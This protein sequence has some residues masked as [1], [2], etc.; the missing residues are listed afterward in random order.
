[1]D[2]EIIS[3]ESRT[4]F[5]R[6][7][8]FTEAKQ[9]VLKVPVKRDWHAQKRVLLLRVRQKQQS[10]NEKIQLT[11]L[12][13]KVLVFAVKLAAKEDFEGLHDE[14]RSYLAES[15]IPQNYFS[16]ARMASRDPR[17]TRGFT[18]TFF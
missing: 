9:P 5:Q 16:H 4:R 7:P 3:I 15:G 8:F 10:L 14:F 6:P 12:C 17:R 13:A 18:N 2:N 11:L 1:M